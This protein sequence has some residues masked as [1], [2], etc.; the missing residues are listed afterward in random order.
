MDHYPWA[1]WEARIVGLV[2][3]DVNRIYFHRT[4]ARKEYTRMR[5]LLGVC[6]GSAWRMRV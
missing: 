4:A 1:T 6:A 2:F 3:D 5:M